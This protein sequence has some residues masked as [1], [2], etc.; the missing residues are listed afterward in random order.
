MQTKSSRLGFVSLCPENLY[1]CNNTLV[2]SSS[3]LSPPPI[4]YL[5]PQDHCHCQIVCATNDAPQLIMLHTE[6]T[7]YSPIFQM[8]LGTRLTPCHDIINP[9]A[10]ENSLL[11]VSL[12]FIVACL[13]YQYQ[14]PM[15]FSA[16]QGSGGF[17][18]FHG[19][20]R[21]KCCLHILSKS[22]QT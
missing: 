7:M 16:I 9:N 3:E 2:S 11:F 13:M 18:G 10:N 8:G 21:L 6:V 5:E 12:T 15:R 14:Q 20:P 17:H 4:S 19:T 1:Q 22:L